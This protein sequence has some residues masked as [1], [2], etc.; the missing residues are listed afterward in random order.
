MTYGTRLRSRVVPDPACGTCCRSTR[1][2]DR[3]KQGRSDP[4]GGTPSSDVPRCLFLLLTPPGLLVLCL[5]AHWLHIL[6][7]LLC[8]QATKALV[9]FFYQCLPK[10][11]SASLRLERKLYPICQSCDSP[12]AYCAWFFDSVV[13][14]PNLAPARIDYSLC[15]ASIGVVDLI[16]IVHFSCSAGG[17]SPIP[18]AVVKIT[19]YPWGCQG[20]GCSDG[21]PCEDVFL[22]H[23]R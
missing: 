21:Y 3:Q 7:A 20:E 14:N 16:S 4:V 22:L 19:R 12:A 17:Q 5:N 13:D 1:S 18:G 10:S 8:S 11:V 6:S 15:S 9:R 23:N 2:E